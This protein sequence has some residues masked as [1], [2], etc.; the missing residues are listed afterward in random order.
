MPLKTVAQGSL[1]WVE[2]GLLYGYK[3]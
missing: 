3:G 2:Y 1:N